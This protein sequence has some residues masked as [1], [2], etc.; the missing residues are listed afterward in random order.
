M[1]QIRISESSLTNIY[2]YT[3]G[4]PPSQVASDHQDYEPCLGLGIPN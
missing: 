3:L 2:I 4:C 1:Q